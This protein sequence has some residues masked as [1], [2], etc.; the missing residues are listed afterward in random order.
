MS[1]RGRK[2]RQWACIIVRFIQAQSMQQKL[3]AHVL[4]ILAL[5]ATPPGVFAQ[6]NGL[7]ANPSTPSILVAQ[8]TAYMGTI[9]LDVDATDLDHRV[10]QVRQQMPVKP[11]PLTL[12]F[13]RWLPGT[14]GPTGSIDRLAGLKVRTANQSVLPWQRDTT[15]PFAFHVTVPTGVSKLDLEFQHLSPIDGRGTRVVMTR[16]MLNL[17]WNSMLLYPAG[18]YS[19]RITV[20]ASVKL[21]SGWQQA[22]ALQV[23][24]TSDKGFEFAPVSLEKLVDSPLFAGQNV[25]RVPLDPEG[26]R[27]PVVLNIV[28][29]SP[30]QLQASEEQLQAHKNLVQQADR[31]FGARHYERYHF[32]LALSERM[33][34]IGLEHHESSEN[35]VRP[36]YFKDWAKRIGSRELLPHEYVH[37][38]NGK[39]RRPADLN[40]NTF[41]EP[42]R[43]SLLWLYEG[44][45]Q[46]WG[47]VLAARSGLVTAEQARDGLANTAASLDAR[48][49]RTWRNLQDTTNEGTMGARRTGKDW[50]NYQRSADYYDESA[51]IWL[52]AD[53]LIREK[54]G[55]SKSMDDFAQ[56]FFG[57][58]DGRVQPLPYTFDDI[59]STLN[60]VQ[61]YDWVGF[62]RA[63]LDG[64]GP[65]APMDGLERAGWRLSYAEKPSEF[66][67][68]DDREDRAEDFAYSLGLTLQ[69][70]GKV[71]SV[72]WGSP[73]FNAGLNIAVQVVAVNGR[74]YKAERL[75]DAITANK[76]GKAPLALLLKEGDL[77][78]T[79]ALDYRGGLRYPRLERIANAPER[80]DAGLLA[81]RL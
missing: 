71:D 81:P 12:F 40:T 26:S 6:P 72:L 30:E 27:R 66:A 37:S 25:R 13:P 34:G 63:R 54:S 19:N 2:S 75:S 48:A 7:I 65:G 80:L 74:S 61:A 29:D 50:S 14:H 35:G 70:D 8:N 3:T 46:F 38:W 62:L 20:A 45:T 18:Y 32:L 24:A 33:T 47:K 11:G 78:R 77:Y 22:S 69:K 17:Q 36:G 52:D 4:A 31:L 28:A 73:A 59:V 21:P 68:N 1:G 64:N 10:F 60:R 42:M 39:F 44:Q 79:V 16:D 49:G 53:S 41:N 58:E 43:N 23:Q 5:A 56:L 9:V 57:V 15:D 67:R 55:G 76:E 51:L